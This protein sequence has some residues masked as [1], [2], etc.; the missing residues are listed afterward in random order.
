[1][2]ELL[3]ALDSALDLLSRDV[4]SKKRID[5]T[6]EFIKQLEEG[7]DVASNFS[8]WKE[9]THSGLKSK[10][11]SLIKFGKSLNPLDEWS[12]SD[13]YLYHIEKN[14]H[15]INI[16][17]N[18]IKL[19]LIRNGNINIFKNDVDLKLILKFNE[20]NSI[21]KDILE[22]DLNSSIKWCELNDSSSN[23]LFQLNK[24]QFYQILKSDKIEAFHYAQLNFKKF[25]SNSNLQSISKLMSCLLFDNQEDIDLNYLS[26]LFTQ[27]FSNKLGFPS[28]STLDTLLL[29][30]NLSLPTLL[31]FLIIQKL[32]NLNWSTI[33]ELPFEIKLPDFLKFHPVFICPVSKEETGLKGNEAFGLPCGHIISK[34]SLERLSGKSNNS[35]MYGNGRFKCPYCPNNATLGE[36]HEVRFYNI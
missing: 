2:T 10:N 33:D 17:N 30:G 36:C 16:I 13:A 24:L 1:M 12:L 29:A 19:H 27:D 4:S 6:T 18:L 23:L 21:E 20:M 14:D 9:S 7:G 8:T 11:S 22:G 31:K 28:T 25:V 5:A 35:R 32:K 26:K 34:T 3:D 15:S